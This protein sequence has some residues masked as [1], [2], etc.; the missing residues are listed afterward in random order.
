MDLNS[1]TSTQ[2]SPCYCAG[3]SNTLNAYTCY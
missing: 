2:S 3:N 1:I